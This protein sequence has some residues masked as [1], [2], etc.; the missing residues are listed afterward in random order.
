MYVAWGVLYAPSKGPHTR[1]VTPLWVLW[2][3]LWARKLTHTSR[4]IVH[5][6]SLEIYLVPHI[7]MIEQTAFSRNTRSSDLCLIFDCLWQLGNSTIGQIKYQFGKFWQFRIKAVLI[8]QYYYFLLVC[9]HVC[10][11]MAVFEQF[12]SPTNAHIHFF[13]LFNFFQVKHFDDGWFILENF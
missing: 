6:S 5:F 4:R 13:L 9:L 3:S 1:G 2:R 11:P 7:I 10:L 12:S 8:I